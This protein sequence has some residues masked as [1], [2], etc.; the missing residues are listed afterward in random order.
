MNLVSRPTIIPVTRHWDYRASRIIEQE[1]GE[2]LTI[3]PYMKFVGL[4]RL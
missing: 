2:K 4:N 3:T 1:Q